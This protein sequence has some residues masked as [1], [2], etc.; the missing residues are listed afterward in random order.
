MKEVSRDHRTPNLHLFLKNKYL[1][2]LISNSISEK[3]SQTLLEVLKK[4]SQTSVSNSKQVSRTL[5]E[6]FLSRSGRHIKYLQRK[7][8]EFA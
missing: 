3:N 1:E 8:E 5:S 7:L 4:V 6:V 2:F